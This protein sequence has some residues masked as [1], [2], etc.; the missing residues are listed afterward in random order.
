MAEELLIRTVSQIAYDSTL[1]KHAAVS[2]LTINT[3][4][5]EDTARNKYS[6]FGPNISDMSLAV[7]N[8][9]ETVMPIIRQANMSDVT[10]DVKIDFFTVP[11]GNESGSELKT[12]PFKRYLEKIGKYTSNLEQE[13]LYLPRDEV[14]LT[15]PQFCILPAKEKDVYFGVKLFNYQS[16]KDNPVVLAIVVSQE[17]TSAQVVTEEHQTL[18]F[19]KAGRSCNFAA[20]RLSVDRRQRGVEMKEAMTRDEQERNALIVF[21]IPLKPKE[22]K[23]QFCLEY[24][25]STTMSGPVYR[26]LDFGGEETTSGIEDAVLKVGKDKGVFVGTKD[27]DGNCLKLVRD[28]DYPIRCTI[29]FYQITDS[30]F[31][32]GF[33]FQNMAQKIDEVFS[34]GEA[35]GSLVFSMDKTRKT[36]PVL[37]TTKAQKATAVALAK[38]GQAKKDFGGKEFTQKDEVNTCGANQTE[39]DRLL[40]GEM[41]D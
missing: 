23:R 29:Q 28:P 27:S 40:Y 32:G 41:V 13:S 22:N 33:V 12:I 37:G 14:I 21:Q 38:A 24:D 9:T 10:T 18:Y 8:Q 25:D 31:I 11:V 5:W 7:D 34:H 17:G 15:S 39:E 4:S 6:A 30:P 1:A 3:I 2:G 26:G 35:S 20:K 19:N 16:H 36:E